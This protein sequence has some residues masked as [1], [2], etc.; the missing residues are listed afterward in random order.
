MC[1]LITIPDLSPVRLSYVAA[2]RGVKPRAHGAAFTYAQIGCCDPVSAMCLAASNPEGHFYYAMPDEAA[3][4]RARDLAAARQ[5]GNITFLAGAPSVLLEQH[6]ES[7]ARLPAL[8]YLVFDAVEQ[9][10]SDAER[11]ALFALAEKQLKPSGLFA[12]RYR[13]AGDADEILSFLINELTPEMTANQAKEFLRELK[14]LGTLY[15]ADHP[16]AQTVL[17]RAIEENTPAEFFAACAGKAKAR[18]YAFDVMER[19]LP[20]GFAFAGD[21]DV[22]ANYMEL[23]TLLEAHEVL[24]KCRAH[25]LYEPIKDFSMHRLERCDIWCRMPADQTGDVAALY[26]GFTFGITVP[27][28]QVPAGIVAQGKTIN[29]RQPP[30]D[31]LIELMAMLPAGIGDFLAHPKG[32]GVNATDAVAAV[33]TLVALGVARPMRSSYQRQEESA[34]FTQPKWAVSYNGYL[35][36]EPIESAKILLASAIVGSPVP[37]AARDALVMQALARVGLADSVVALLPELHRVASDP[38]LASQIMDVAEPTAEVAHNMIQSAVQQS[39][40]RWYAFGLLA[41]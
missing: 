39:A 25:L 15:F 28:E 31:K 40:V 32:Q 22:R 34:S 33:Q 16:S 7:I 3:A 1:A 4:T 6:A 24:D 19:L 37:V 29:L 10:L 8:D 35:D 21:A 2:L 9:P 12:Y 27:Y 13:A 38:A 26:G 30:F 17:E 20:R 5:V 18:S 36:D 23:A 11:E 41:A 14:A